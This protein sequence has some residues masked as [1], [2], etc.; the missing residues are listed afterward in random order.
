MADLADVDLVQE[1]VDYVSAIVADIDPEDEV[2]RRNRELDFLNWV[3]RQP[4]ELRGVAYAGP[5]TGAFC[6]P[7][8]MGTMAHHD[9]GLGL[10]PS[11]L[12]CV[13]L[14]RGHHDARHGRV[15][16]FS[17]ER[18]TRWDEHRWRLAAI[19]RTQLR[20]VRWRAGEQRVPF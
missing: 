19:A 5:C 8:H 15:G 9:R 2:A 20:Y 10:K 14:C 12:T 18:M 13:P 7:D 6:D 4:C 17:T 3:R 1:V 11:D 16:Y